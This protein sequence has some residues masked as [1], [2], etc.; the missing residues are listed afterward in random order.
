[1][2]QHNFNYVIAR[3]W[4]DDTESLCCYMTYA[5]VVHY[6]TL[7]DAKEH[8]KY[9]ISRQEEGEPTDYKIYK[10]VPYE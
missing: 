1:M 6:G 4:G 10:V 8:L 7:E 5:N 9:V 3:P 2:S